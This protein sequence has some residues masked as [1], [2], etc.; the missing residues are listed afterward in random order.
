MSGNKKI[1][2]ANPKEY[3]GI[4]FKSLLEVMTYKTLLQENIVPE[5][6]THTYLIWEGFVPTIPFLTKNTLKRKDKRC[7]PLSISTMQVRKPINGITYTPDFY[8]EYGDKKIIVEVK[9]VA[10]DVYPYKFKMFRKYLEEQPDKDAYIIW[11]IHTKKQLLECVNHLKT[12][13]SQ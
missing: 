6:E 13:R 2:N 11:E 1:K 8:F 9:G 12:S 7:I 10:N 3:N 4:Q 5:Y